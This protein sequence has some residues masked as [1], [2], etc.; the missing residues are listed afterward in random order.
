M[1][2]TKLFTTRLCYCYC[3]YYCGV[4]FLENDQPIDCVAMMVIDLPFHQ[5]L[6]D[7]VKSKW[8]ANRYRFVKKVEFG[9]KQ[10]NAVYF[11]VH[12]GRRRYFLVA[13][14]SSIEH[15]CHDVVEFK[16]N[17]GAD[18]IGCASFYNYDQVDDDDTNTSIA[19]LCSGLGESLLHE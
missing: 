4:F 14:F 10:V 13:V 3:N 16:E 17:Y 18:V 6:L 2:L 9:S 1:K 15:V 8:T 12:F 7:H 11:E 5:S 19:F